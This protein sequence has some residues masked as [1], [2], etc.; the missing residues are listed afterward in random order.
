MQTRPLR[1][2]AR[3]TTTDQAYNAILSAILDGSIPAGAA[4]PLQHLAK[5]LGMSMMPVREAIR[6]LEATGI[7]EVEPHRGA[8]VRSLTD[9]DLI[10]TYLTRIV[11]EGALVKQ[12]AQN[13][14]TDTARTAREALDAQQLALRLDDQAGARKAHEDF[15]FTV[16]RAAGSPWLFRSIGP[17]WHN[18]ERYRAGALADP[19]QVEYRRREHE[20]ILDR[21][22]ARDPVEAYQALEAHLLSTVEGFHAE[23]A[24][25]LRELLEKQ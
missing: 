10:D 8:R 20:L 21:C 3:T 16:Y 19:V 14:D 5:D 1:A 22:L 18:S 24:A 17:T 23:A 6:Q 9:E 7:I 15:H 4:L 13:F 2:P 11:L 12:A 25:R